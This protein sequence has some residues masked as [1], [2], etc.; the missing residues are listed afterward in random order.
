MTSEHGVQ[1]SESQDG[2]LLAI[3]KR[4]VTDTIMRLQKFSSRFSS[5]HATFRLSQ[6]FEH[7]AHA[8]PI[9]K[10]QPPSRVDRQDK[11]VKPDSIKWG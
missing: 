9:I 10:H 5:L 1:K 3:Y 2:R 4:Q 7:I 8:A 6:T 11:L